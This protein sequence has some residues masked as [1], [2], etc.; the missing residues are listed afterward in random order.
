MVIA[1]IAIRPILEASLEF[2]SQIG[3]LPLLGLRGN[4]VDIYM[5]ARSQFKRA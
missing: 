5:P 2:L 4:G 1:D 3:G